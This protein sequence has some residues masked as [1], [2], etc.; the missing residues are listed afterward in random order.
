[1]V[2]SRGVSVGGRNRERLRFVRA[3]GKNGGRFI[4]LSPFSLSLS[5]SLFPFALCMKRCCTY[6]GDGDSIADAAERRVSLAVVVPVELVVTTVK[7]V[8]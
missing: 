6:S 3:T 4:R 8:E 1:M 7:L 5:L 2:V